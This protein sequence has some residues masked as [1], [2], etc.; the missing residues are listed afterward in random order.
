MGLSG[1]DDLVV[2]FGRR[3][4]RA[5][6]LMLEYYS[7]NSGEGITP[8]GSKDKIENAREVPKSRPRRRRAGQPTTSG[9]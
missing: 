1:L 8:I 9:W 2:H 4:H 7:L 6:G 5:A 3:P